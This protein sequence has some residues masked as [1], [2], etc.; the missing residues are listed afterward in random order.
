VLN[1]S[2][3]ELGTPE[4]TWRN[5][6]QL[7]GLRRMSWGAPS[8]VVVVAPHPDDEV[9]AVGGSVRHLA[10]RGA[11]VVVV[12]VTDGEASHPGSRAMTPPDLARA[13]R[14]ERT[15]ALRTLGVGEPVVDRLRVPD[16][17]VV[18]FEQEVASVLLDHLGPDTVCLATWQHDGH[19]DHEAT[20]RAASD[21]AHTA[22]ATFVEYPVWAWHWATPD[23]GS[24]PERPHALPW[25]RARRHDLDAPSRRDKVAAIGAYTT[26]IAPI[27]PDPA[28]R[29]VLPNAVLDRF[30]RPFEVLF[31]PETAPT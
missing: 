2:E 7:V 26:Q 28:D 11:E 10:A 18:R 13:R 27:G 4:A 3:T 19:P 12:A 22:G 16:G 20:G 25:G 21:A 29:R 17:Q 30:R 24:T 15:A 8:R 14:A 23:G 5:A 9:L 1:V 31:L 6:P